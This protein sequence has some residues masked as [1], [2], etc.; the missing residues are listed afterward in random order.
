M[1]IHETEI[2]ELRILEL[3]DAEKGWMES[4]EIAERLDLS[5]PTVKKYTLELKHV[6]DSFD[7]SRVSL[8]LAPNKG[9]LLHHAADFSLA[10]VKT[11][12]IKDLTIVRLVDAILEK[13]FDVLDF[14]VNENISESSTRRLVSRIRN[15]VQAQNVVLQNGALEGDERSVRA[16]FASFYWQMYRGNYWPFPTVDRH[17]VENVLSQYENSFDYELLPEMREEVLYWLAVNT[18]RFKQGFR[19]A[20]DPEIEAFTR[21]HPLYEVFRKV[22]ANLFGT[23]SQELQKNLAG[24][25]QYD[26]YFINAL[27]AIQKHEKYQSMFLN[28]HLAT[29][30]QVLKATDFWLEK[31]EQTFWSINDLQT[32]ERLRT[33]LLRIHAFS[34]LFYVDYEYLPSEE[35]VVALFSRQKSLISQVTQLAE[36]ANNQFPAIGHNQTYLRNYYLVL[37]VQFFDVSQL[38]DVIFVAVSLSEGDLFEN[39]LKQKITYEL[40]NRARVEFVNRSEPHDVLVTNLVTSEENTRDI[41]TIYVANGMSQHEMQHII[42]EILTL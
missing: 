15:F 31:F 34:Y 27:P 14:A 9:V 8:R 3:L 38:E 22:L 11:K 13:R 42:N 7:D 33:T 17:F 12:F 35:G 41:V 10:I 23:D 2:I 39:L 18:I 30:G 37:I 25:I 29:G 28:A 5:R 20:L 26:F 19:V 32:K 36:L 16:F 40:G 4:N 1:L 6:I 21:Q 24:E